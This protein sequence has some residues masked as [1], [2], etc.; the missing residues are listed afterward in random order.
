MAKFGRNRFFTTLAALVS[1]WLG[2]LV[3]IVVAVPACVR[4]YLECAHAYASC[5]ARHCAEVFLS[6]CS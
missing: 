5:H 6:L 3:Y 2:K 4:F 1:L